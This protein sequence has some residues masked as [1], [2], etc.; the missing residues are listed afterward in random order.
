MM[1]FPHPY[2]QGHKCRC[3]LHCLSDARWCH[4]SCPHAHSFCVSSIVKVKHFKLEKKKKTKGYFSS[5][6]GGINKEQ[7]LLQ[8][9]DF[10]KKKL[11]QTT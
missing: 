4:A 10:S 9:Y 7:L 1:L 6:P 11:K 2:V 5:V 8:K 3:S